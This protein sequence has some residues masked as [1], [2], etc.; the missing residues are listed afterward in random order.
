MAATKASKTSA[1][2][3][4]FTSSPDEVIDRDLRERYMQL[5]Q[6]ANKYYEANPEEI[7]SMM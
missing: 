7:E 6:R 3:V 1:S 5:L 4:W 2:I